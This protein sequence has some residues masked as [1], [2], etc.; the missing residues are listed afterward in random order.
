MIS[1][2]A[3]VEKFQYALNNDWGYIWGTSGQKWTQAKQNA[4]TREQ[5]VKYG[6]K[7]IGHIVAD[8]SGLFSWA[9]EQLGG[10]MYHGSNTMYDS[11]CTSKGKLKKG[12]RDDGKDMLPG[13]AVFTGD[14]KRHG[15]VGLYI[16]D[17][18]VIE[19]KGTQS[20]VVKSKVSDSKWTYW[21]ELKG[22]AYGEHTVSKPTL[23]KGD[24][25]EYV[26]VLQT[27]LINRGYDLG[28]YG[29]DGKFGKATEKAVKAF[30]S[31]MGLTADG[32]VGPKT[33]EALEKAEEPRYTATITGLS[34]TQAS[35]ILKQFPTADIVME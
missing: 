14:D 19:A 18:W 11:W 13:T 28:T 34:K 23:A 9:F 16:G 15:H 3:L 8:C 22:V 20:G 26:V 25:G 27:A 30:Q 32:V 10:K 21:G 17:G 4:A 31:N 35:A 1:T 2:Q 24:S 7:W 6:A 12:C 5:T 33:W 29:A